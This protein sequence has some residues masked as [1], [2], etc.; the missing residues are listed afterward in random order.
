MRRPSLLL[1]CTLGLHACNSSTP[2]PQPADTTVD[3]TT[4][5]VL[6]SFHSNG[7]VDAEVPMVDGLQHGTL[8]A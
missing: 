6:R 1:L 3:S 4:V 7:Q 2:P 5:N 8:T